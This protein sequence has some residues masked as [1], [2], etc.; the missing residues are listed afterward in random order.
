MVNDLFFVN[1]QRVELGTLRSRKH[2]RIAIE[3]LFENMLIA[4]I[5]ASLSKLAT[6]TLTISELTEFLTSTNPNATFDKQPIS[7]ALNIFLSHYAK[8]SSQHTTIGANKSYS[9]NQS[10]VTSGNLGAGLTA[11]RGF[12]PSIRVVLPAREDDFSYQIRSELA[13]STS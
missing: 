10:E 7:Q 12:F 8:A 5:A 2:A 13:D 3:V 4:V 6:V 11:L 1:R 9:L